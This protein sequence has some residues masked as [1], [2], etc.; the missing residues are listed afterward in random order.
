MDEHARR[1][2]ADIARLFTAE[3]RDAVLTTLETRGE[4]AA[5]RLEA[6]LLAARRRALRPAPQGE[7]LSLL[8]AP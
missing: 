4:G 5:L 6:K 2:A 7:Q 8:V 3:D 1:R